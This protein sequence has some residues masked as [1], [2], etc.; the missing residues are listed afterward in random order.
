PADLMGPGLVVP[1]VAVVRRRWARDRLEPAP[2]RKSARNRR[3]RSRSARGPRSIG[4]ERS[5]ARATDPRPRG[6]CRPPAPGIDAREPKRPESRPVPR[7]R[8]A[9]ARRDSSSP[10]TPPDRADQPSVPP[11]VSGPLIPTE[12]GLR[13]CARE[14]RTRLADVSAD[15]P[16]RWA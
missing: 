9:D 7:L 6:A 11:A 13:W 1:E 5:F 4:Q 10:R 8:R 14:A 3:S 16:P 2:E 15:H 12:G